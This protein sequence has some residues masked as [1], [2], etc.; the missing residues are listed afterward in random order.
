MN[1]RLRQRRDARRRKQRT[2]RLALAV[3]TLVVAGVVALVAVLARGG[4]DDGPQL[5]AAAQA[6]KDA[7]VRGGCVGCHGRSGEGVTAPSWIGL[8]GSTITL[9]D[10]TSIVVD[11]A[12]L[13]ESIL[14]PAAKKPAGGWPN[15]PAES[16]VNAADVQ[17]IITY[18]EAL[19]TPATP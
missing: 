18:I 10:G 15:M 19:A 13:A 8:Y 6:G 4:G 11:D 17:A 1:D 7:A 2:T 3:G 14:D 9:D 5:S 16:T 12:Y